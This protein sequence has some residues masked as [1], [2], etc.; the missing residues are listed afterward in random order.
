MK[1]IETIWHLLLYNALEHKKFKS[2]QAEI[3]NL[4]GFSLSTVNL[5]IEVPSQIGA[6]RKESKFFIVEDIMKFLFYWGSVRALQKEIIYSTRI[7][8]SVSEIEGLI[9]SGGVYACC[10]AAS[11]IL[12]SKPADYDKVYIYL[13]R[14]GLGDIKAR[15]PENVKQDH[16]FFVIEKSDG[17]VNEKGVTTLPQTF[18]DVWN[19]PDWYAKDYINELTEK[20]HDAILS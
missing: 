6:I 9:P 11:R 13:D 8:A 1:K 3:A 16:N 19:M 15:F 10:S 17:L 14:S 12:K 18:V 2:T 20:I 5:A 4:T 7:D